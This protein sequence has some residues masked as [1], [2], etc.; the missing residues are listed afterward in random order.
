M[1]SKYKILI[2]KPEVKRLSVRSKHTTEVGH[3]GCGGA[4][5]IKL[6]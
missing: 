3:A 5:W 2:R 4:D 6:A 1:R